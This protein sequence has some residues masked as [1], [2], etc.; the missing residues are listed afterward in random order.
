M[1]YASEFSIPTD[2]QTN[3]LMALRWIHFLA[4]ITW[5]G[6]L[7]FFNLV[8]VP[9]MK[10]LD[11]ATKGKVM[12]TLM[13]RALF[14]FRWA[15]VVTVLAG[16]AYWGQI[17]ASDAHNAGVSM[18]T[19]LLSFFVVWT[20]TWG[21][22][23]ALLLPGKGIMD[24][25][26]FLAILYAI[27]VAH[28]IHLYLHW[29]SGGWES[30]RMLSIGVGGG[31]GWMMLLNVWGV[32]WR[33]QKRLIAWTKANAENGTPMPESAKRMARIAFLTSRANAYLSIPL[34]FFMGAASHYPM[35]GR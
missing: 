9:L 30:N 21:I 7:Y 28:S 12:P 33:I 26:W 23:Y 19:P 2:F 34:L 8:N 6:L 15:A 24:Q 35:F 27:I 25:G 18:T 17:V 11:P 20:I 10:E 31:I 29:N 5:I 1:A 3:F 13:L 14:W 16:L 4:G 22:L 32:I